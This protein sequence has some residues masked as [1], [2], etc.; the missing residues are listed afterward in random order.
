M[1]SPIIT[2]VIHHVRLTV[3]DVHRAQEFYTKLLGFQ[4]ASELPPAMVL[5]SNGSIILVLSPAPER[6]ISGDQFDPNRVGLDHLSF[7]VAHRDDLD[8]AVR[9]LDERESHVETSGITLTSESPSSRFEIP[10]AFSWN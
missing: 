8:Q 9:V 5:L 6:P 4:V 10:T 1:A 3:T 7:Q 2:G